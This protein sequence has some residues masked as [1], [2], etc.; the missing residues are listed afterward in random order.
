MPCHTLGIGAR[1]GRRTA[2]ATH[3]CTEDPGGIGGGGA[4]VVVLAQS[5][6]VAPA[7]LP[8]HAIYTFRAGCCATAT[9][10]MRLVALDLGHGA[11][12]AGGAQHQGRR[13]RRRE[14]GRKQ[15][16]IHNALGSRLSLRSRY[17]V[18]IL[19]VLDRQ[20]CRFP[21]LRQ[22]FYLVQEKVR[23][24]LPWDEELTCRPS[25]PS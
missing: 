1:A 5:L 23:V 22:N 4:V 8:R 12:V 18:G 13:G 24:K 17:L 6:R 20:N 25:H 9:S 16:Q 10:R 2:I 3:S 19:T 11:A 7:M 15:F 21:F 14:R